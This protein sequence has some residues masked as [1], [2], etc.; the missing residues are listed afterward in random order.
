MATSKKLVTYSRPKRTF[1][2]TPRASSDPNWEGR[3]AVLC[4][5]WHAVEMT[6][7][8]LIEKISSLVGGLDT[9]SV[10][11]G[12]CTNHALL[13][14]DVVPEKDETTN[15]KGKYQTVDDF[16]LLGWMFTTR[17]LTAT[18]SAIPKHHLPSLLIT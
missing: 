10:Q 1:I 16:F 18:I 2:A 13:C 9:L 5:S 11:R 7:G 4:S 15:Q 17:I 14:R 3:P 6:S 12:C 8:A